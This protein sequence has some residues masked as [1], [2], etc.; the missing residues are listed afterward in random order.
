M[1][2]IFCRFFVISCPLHGER[3]S[4]Q[5]A[6]L[7]P[8]VSETDSEDVTYVE[9]SHPSYNSLS[10]DRDR[11]FL[12]RWQARDLFMPSQL[13]EQVAT[14]HVVLTVLPKRRC[15]FY[16]RQGSRPLSRVTLP[17]W[18]EVHRAGLLA[19]LATGH[20]SFEMS[21][22]YTHFTP[23]IVRPSFHCCAV[24]R[25][26]CLTKNDLSLLPSQLDEQVAKLQGPALGVVLTVFAQ[27]HAG[28][29]SG[30]DV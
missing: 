2:K 30:V 6:S 29:Y 12:V 14:S 4:V 16:R 28:D 19:G 24:G 3:V 13:D 10:H 20:P 7:T 15:R 18:N 1:R 9:Y 25:I 22:A 21:L 8:F 27:E 23:L 17:L 11:L 26:P 5:L